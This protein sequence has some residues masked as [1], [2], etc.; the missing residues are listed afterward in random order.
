MTALMELI[1]AQPYCEFQ[2]RVPGEYGTLQSNL[3]DATFSA[4]DVHTMARALSP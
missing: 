2:P 3:V 4:F 1:I